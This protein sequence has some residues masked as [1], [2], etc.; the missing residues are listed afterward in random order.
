MNS[1]SK[2]IIEKFI[3]GYL[4]EYQSTVFAYNSSR[5]FDNI[6]SKEHILCFS[7]VNPKQTRVA[8]NIIS[9]DIKIKNISYYHQI[10]I[11]YLLVFTIL[12]F[13]Y[14]I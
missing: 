4:S 7:F 3:K 8:C 13:K 2:S 10:H 12:L 14:F 9:S 5:V 11:N 1:F 6:S